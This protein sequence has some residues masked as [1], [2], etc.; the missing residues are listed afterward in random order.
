MEDGA[1]VVAI[2]GSQAF[3]I[4]SG[5]P[6]LMYLLSRKDDQPADCVKL[7]TNDRFRHPAVLAM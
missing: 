4:C 6:D 7:I 1:V 2:A 5:R 3:C